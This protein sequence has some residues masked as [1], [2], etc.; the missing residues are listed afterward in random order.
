MITDFTKSFLKKGTNFLLVIGGF[1]LILV[2]SIL[3]GV[4]EHKK[5]D[6]E[7]ECMTKVVRGWRAFSAVWFPLSIFFMIAIIIWGSSCSTSELFK[8][9][10]SS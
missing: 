8:K 4:F 9:F 3:A 7:C 2:P 5:G 10:V 1:I 6:D